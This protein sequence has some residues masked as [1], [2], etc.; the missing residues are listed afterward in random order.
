MHII[1]GYNYDLLNNTREFINSLTIDSTCYHDEAIG[2][3][4]VPSRQLSLPAAASWPRIKHHYNQ[5][6]VQ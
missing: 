3:P 2:S 6:L 4:C 1:N 5:A